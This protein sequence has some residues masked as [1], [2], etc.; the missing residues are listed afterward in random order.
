MTD[1]SH[2]QKSLDVLSCFYL[3]IKEEQEICHR[4]DVDDQTYVKVVDSLHEWELLEDEWTGE[5]AITER[6]K[7]VL[8]YYH[9]YSTAL[10]VTPAPGIVIEDYY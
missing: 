10:K 9:N 1:R 2:F 6:G 3:D 5:N 7:R 4:A 8:S